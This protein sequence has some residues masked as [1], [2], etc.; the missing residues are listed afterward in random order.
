MDHLF[1]SLTDTGGIQQKD[2]ATD[3]IQVKMQKRCQRLIAAKSHDI[4]G[5]RLQDR[6]DC[7]FK[8]CR[9]QIVYGVLDL[10]DICCQY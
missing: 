8:G 9:I 10:F 7:G 2:F 1:K 3:H 4:N 5:L 6:G